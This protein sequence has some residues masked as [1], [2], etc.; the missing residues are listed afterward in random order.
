MQLRRALPLTLAAL[1][2]ATGCVTVRP[3][4]PPAAV[5]P[6]PAADRTGSTSPTLAAAP[7]GRLPG[8]VESAAPPAPPAPRTASA[9]PP[10][11]APR[12]RRDRA[13]PPVRRVPAAHAAPRARPAPKPRAPS[14]PAPRRTWDMAPLCA[15]ARGTISPAIVALCR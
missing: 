12:P 2:L 1:L 13:A 5:R 6:G 9:A 15:A 4:A 8:P 14:R 7:L 3:P 10:T 11:G